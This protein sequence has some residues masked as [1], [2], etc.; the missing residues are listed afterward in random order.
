[1]QPPSQAPSAKADSSAGAAAAATPQPAALQHTPVA[2]QKPAARPVRRGLFGGIRAKRE[3]RKSYNATKQ[4]ES[5]LLGEVHNEQFEIEKL[6][7]LKAGVEA[8]IQALKK[9][10]EQLKSAP[11]AVAPPSPPASVAPAPSA[12]ATQQTPPA[13]APAPQTQPQGSTPVGQSPYPDW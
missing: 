7:A 9:E 1:V 8:R 13:P 2:Q 4:K 5:K 3:Y 6:K 12:P 10:I 11:T